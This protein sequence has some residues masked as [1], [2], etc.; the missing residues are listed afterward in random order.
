MR[1]WNLGVGSATYLGR[2]EIEGE[3]EV[4]SESAGQLTVKFLYDRMGWRFF[5]LLG[6]RH[7]D[8]FWMPYSSSVGENLGERDRLPLL[9]WTFG[10]FGQRIQLF[11]SHCEGM[12]EKEMSSLS[13]KGC[14]SRRLERKG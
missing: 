6:C 10:N 13:L 12:A 4:G 9:G 3:G 1:L 7:F 5:L 11:W 2:A 8:N 14:V